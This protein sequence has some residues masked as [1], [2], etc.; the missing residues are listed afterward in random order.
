MAQFLSDAWFACVQTL[1]EKAG[2]LPLSPAFANAIVNVFVH[3][4][5]DPSD[6]CA[7]RLQSGKIQKGLSKDATG[8]IAVDKG[9]LCAL[10]QDPD[11]ATSKALQAFLQGQIRVEGD[12]STLLNLH[13][14]KIS[15]E[16]KQL[17]KDI[18]ANT[19]FE[20]K[21]EP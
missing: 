15:Q 20:Q 8:C 14:Q 2:D 1:N 3:T 11:N 9:C 5:D 6:N 21:I 4:A 18:L 12:V 19:E 17:F 13:T 16:H 7:A 10:L